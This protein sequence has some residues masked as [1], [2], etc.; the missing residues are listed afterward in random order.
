MKIVI[1]DGYT[2]NPGDLSWDSLHKYGEV[3]YYDRT[4]CTGDV[5]QRIQGA[6]IVLLNKVKITEDILI[7]CPAVKLICVLATGYD[8]VDIEA[9]KK[10]GVTVCNVPAY[11]TKAVAQYTFALLLELCHRV[12]AHSTSISRNSNGCNFLRNHLFHDFYL[13]LHTCLF[14]RKMYCL[15]SFTCQI[16]RKSFIH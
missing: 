12:G 15:F 16:F 14:R 11:G 10:H 13:R 4:E 2:V 9:A 5:V 7:Q 3:D 8:V 1:L 6:E